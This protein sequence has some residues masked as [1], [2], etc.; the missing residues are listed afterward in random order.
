MFKKIIFPIFL[1]LIITN[2]TFSYDS[3]SAFKEN[4][5]IK[6]G[7]HITLDFIGVKNAETLYTPDFYK[8][9]IQKIADTAHVKVASI[10]DY[11]F[12]PQGYTVLA[13]LLESHMS[14]HTFPELGV[15]SFD[16]F[17]CGKIHPNVAVDILKKAINH[18]RVVHKT[19]ERNTIELYKDVV[20]HKGMQNYY[21]VLDEIAS[22]DSPTGQKIEILKLQDFGVALFIDQ[23]IQVSENDEYLYSQA[24]VELGLEVS[25]KAKTAAIIGGGDG[26]VARECLNHGFESIDWF[27]LDKEVMTVCKNY[28]P[29]IFQN[30]DDHKNVNCVL[31]DAFQSIKAVA[32]DTYDHIFVDLTNED[33]CIELAKSNMSEL[34]R[35]LKKNGAITIQVGTIDKEGPQVQKWINFLQESFGNYQEKSV[36]VPSFDCRWTFV[37]SQFK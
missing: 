7:D 33:Y 19:T 22:I 25:E 34:K 2:H 29:S 3:T 16:F 13:L 24:F 18:E 20:A 27:E 36:F 17:T 9:I 8:D 31:G 10:V 11:K 14:F 12:E 35:I 23:E 26:G 1:S 21:T 32:D 28:L 30:V 6:V 37:S 5:V 4:N 15:I